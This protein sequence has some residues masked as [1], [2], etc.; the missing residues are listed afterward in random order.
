LMFIHFFQVLFYWC[1]IF[2]NL[3]CYGFKCTHIFF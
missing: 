3:H 1:I 2:D